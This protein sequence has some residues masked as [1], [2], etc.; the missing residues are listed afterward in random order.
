MSMKKDAE[1]RVLK[2]VYCVIF[3]VPENKNDSD[4]K[5]FRA[6]AAWL[7]DH[8]EVCIIDVSMHSGE[9]G[10]EDMTT[11]LHVFYEL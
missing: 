4:I 2:D 11:E 10:P 8:P 6:V 5:L 1:M 7:E 3:S 9:C